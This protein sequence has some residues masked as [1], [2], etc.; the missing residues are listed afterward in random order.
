ML[1]GYENNVNLLLSLITTRQQAAGG[2][3][4]SLNDKS[5]EGNVECKYSTGYLQTVLTDI[6]RIIVT[7]DQLRK[8]QSRIANHLTVRKKNLQKHQRHWKEENRD[9]FQG[10]PAKKYSDSDG[11]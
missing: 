10:P 3:Q 9:D 2:G 5:R 7:L 11:G 8:K 1:H 4:S 6:M